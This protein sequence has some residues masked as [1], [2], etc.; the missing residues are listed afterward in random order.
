MAAPKKLPSGRWR[1]RVYL[2]RDDQGR[3]H[4]KS[5]TAD[6]KKEAVLAAAR[7]SAGDG[8]KRDRGEGR[9]SAHSA[10]IGEVVDKYIDL[11]STLSPATISGYEKIRRTGFP[12]LWDVPVD[13]FDDLAAQEAINRESF[14]EGRRGRISAKT[15]T[16]EWML[17]S[18]ALARICHKRFEVRLP[19]KQ[20]RLQEYPEPVTILAAVRGS[21][22][23]LP[24]LLAMWCGLRM[25]EIRGLKWSDLQGDVLRIQRVIVDVDGL[26]VE[27]TAAKTYTSRRLVLVPQ[28]VLDLLHAAPHDSDYI[29]PLTHDQIYNRFRKIMDPLGISITF[30][31]LRHYFASIGVLAGISDY[32][33]QQSGGWASDNVM[34]AVYFNTF[35][36]GQRDAFDRR[37]RYMEDLLLQL[38]LPQKVDTKVDTRLG[39]VGISRRGLG[40]IPLG[41]TMKKVRKPLKK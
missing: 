7:Y 15:L 12:D 32:Y 25:S 38:E 31:D 21:S 36:S 27:K 29:V 39:P 10:T 41:S 11:C 35:T 16:N 40:S 24:C 19:S 3:A 34:K 37:N 1:I 26:H 30:H 23:E 20:R 13:E 18:A 4:F 6:T 9:K 14:R 2:G 5:I 8:V 33:I 28:T 17:V 22:I